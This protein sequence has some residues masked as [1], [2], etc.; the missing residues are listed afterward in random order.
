MILKKGFSICF[1]F[2]VLILLAGCR[3]NIEGVS[4]SNTN[5]GDTIKIL[6]NNRWVRIYYDPSYKLN[7]KI[8]ADSGKWEYESGRIHLRDWIDRDGL[9]HMEGEGK[10]I[11][12]TDIKK[13]FFSGET[14]LM[15]NYD[16]NYY[17]L[18]QK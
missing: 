12:G 5:I 15:V 18:K 16:M 10:V 2:V 17:Y 1:S 4:V 9:Q 14:K 3:N 8:F 11:F 6:S 13:S 7:S